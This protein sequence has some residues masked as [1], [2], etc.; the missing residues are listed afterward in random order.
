MRFQNF[1]RM[2]A[3]LIGFGTALLL[4]NSVPAQEIQN[5]QFDDGPYVAAF[6]QQA[7]TPAAVDSSAKTRESDSLIPSTTIATPIVTQ[8]SLFP[9]WSALPGWVF[10][11]L[12]ICIASLALYVAAEAKRARRNRN[13]RAGS[14]FK[15]RAAYS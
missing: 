13:P 1:L 4:A 11:I 9:I 2:Q 3:V 6:P 12:L 14:Q 15:R 7:Q 5:T 8:A 10:A